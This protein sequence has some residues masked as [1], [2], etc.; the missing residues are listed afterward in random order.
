M[1]MVYPILKQRDSLIHILMIHDNDIL[2]LQQDNLHRMILVKHMSKV[3]NVKVVVHD[4]IVNVLERVLWVSLVSSLL[5]H[6]V[7]SF[8]LLFLLGPQGFPGIPGDR[9]I[10][11]PVGRP[12]TLGLSGEK[13]DRGQYGNK[14]ERVN[15]NHSV[16]FYFSFFFLL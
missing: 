10:K 4:E 7:Y 14:G 5:L 6:N 2:N 13:G 16:L 15:C 3:L 1:M 8:I 9:G 11:G 12:G